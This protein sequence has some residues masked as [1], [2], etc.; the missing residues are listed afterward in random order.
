MANGYVSQVQLPNNETYDIKDKNAVKDI[1]SSDISGNV[2]FVKGEETK[3]ILVKDFGTAYGIDCYKGKL[4]LDF[5]SPGGVIDEW[6]IYGNSSGPAE[7]LET[8]STL[9]IGIDTYGGNA[10]DWEIFGNNENGTENLFDNQLEQGTMDDKG[11]Q[12]ATNRVR[13]DTSVA[14]EANTVYSQSATSIDG[15][16]TLEFIAFGFNGSI[17]VSLFSGWK[18]LNT[19]FNTDSCVLVRMVYRFSDNT[20]ITPADVTNVML[21]KGSTVPQSYIPY[22]QGVGENTEITEELPINFRSNG[23]DLLGYRIYGTTDG[24][25]VQT[26]NLWDPNSKTTNQNGTVQYGVELPAGT[27]TIVNN[28]DLTVY[29]R[30][31]ISSTVAFTW[32]ASGASATKTFDVGCVAWCTRSE[33]N[34]VLVSDSTAPSNYIPYGYKL[35]ITVANGTET[36]TTDIYIGDSKLG[37]EEYVDS[38]T[39][40]IYKYITGLSEPLFGIDTYTDSLDLS[41]GTLTR[42]IKKLVLTGEENWTYYDGFCY[43]NVN[44]LDFRNTTNGLVCSHLSVILRAKFNHQPSV[45]WGMAQAGD[46]CLCISNTI[47]TLNDFKSYLTAQYAA[48]TPVTVWYVLDEPETSTISVPTG[49]TGTIDGYLIQ[50]GT[51]TPN[52]PIYP[53]ANGVKQTDGI[54]SIETVY[55][56][57]LPF[58][59]IETFKGTNTLNSTETLGETMITQ[60]YRIP[61]QIKQGAATKT[62]NFYIGSVPLTE[63]Q[64]I[65]KTST[66][67]EI[68]LYQGENTISTTLGNKPEMKIGYLSTVVGVGERT[69]NLFDKTTA[70]DR[71]RIGP[72]GAP[73]PDPRCKL[74]DYIEVLPNTAYAVNTV[75]SYD[76]AMAQYDANKTFIERTVSGSG[77]FTTTSSTKYVR[78]SML[79][80]N[81]NTKMLVKGSAAPTSYSPYGY[82]IPISIKQ[83]DEVV[84][85]KDIYI[86]TQPLIEG[87]YIN[88]TGVYRRLHQFI[89][90]ASSSSLPNYNFIPI[91]EQL[92]AGNGENT[93]T[94]SLVNNTTIDVELHPTKQASWICD[95]LEN[96]QRRID[97]VDSTL[98]APERRNYLVTWCSEDRL[99]GSTA[100]LDF[101]FNN[102]DSGYSTFLIDGKSTATSA[103]I[104]TIDLLHMINGIAQASSYNYTVARPGKYVVVIFGVEMEDSSSNTITLKII[105]DN[106]VIAS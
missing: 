25:G 40:K 50:D 81:A 42:R 30:N 41:T 52:A 48:G 46:I 4:P 94:T 33:S 91:T 70:T 89:N 67:T 49:L 83:G 74:S 79:N 16:K 37:A 26:E 7:V 65:S 19:D 68:A 32:A 29:A 78:I 99:T 44:S 76:D 85:H 58:P 86:G 36:K 38:A 98:G 54:Y 18:P 104:E 106:V 71:R 22:Q 10:V 72:D 39:G 20:D 82:Q 69:G 96:L 5:T 61:L 56:P 103:F 13:Y 100:N 43:T 55:L 77:S 53:T 87:D 90:Y 57:P 2:S 95:K 6:K 14:V 34:I 88:Q 9:P 93:I 66:G 28:S 75:F 15:S 60:G 64:S 12:S 17:W 27:Y 24:S 97:N 102:K 101:S 21:V 63:G 8:Q 105:R 62:V 23:D 11:E 80:D 31:G 51:P 45:F 47:T 35:P 84:D 3:D 92:I 59:T 73:Y 1:T